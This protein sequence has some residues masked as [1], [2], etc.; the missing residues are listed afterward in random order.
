VST[1][2]VDKAWQSKGLQAYS[3]EAIVG[4]LGH[5]GAPVAE[6]DFRKLA[7]TAWPQDIALQWGKQWKGTGPFKSFPYVA[8]DEL[9]RR[10]VPE[11]L[12][13]RE[14]AEALAELMGALTALLGGRQDAPVGPAFERMKATRQKVPVDDKGQPQLAFV[15]RALGG[16]DEKV[17][18]LFDSM[19][20]ALA[21]A[22]HVGHAEAFA[23]FEE[24]LLPDRRGI[25][26]AVVRA[27]KGERDAAITELENI[28][29]EASRT[30]MAR[31]L[32]VDAMI[33]LAAWP[34]AIARARPMMAQAEKEE[35]IHLALDLC[36]RL[37]HIYK[38][39][40]DRAALQELSRDSAR[41]GELHDR[42]HPGHRHRH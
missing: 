29:A 16:F 33:H 2:R 39:M 42:M 11:K 7:E 40:G 38:A 31:L 13:P 25:A 36:G 12:A 18:E 9:W 34:Q 22:G 23:E 8:A 20:E 15:E 32:A 21:K 3:T 37:Q 17:A 28:S 26:T 27:A 41:L 4:T 24:F 6:A 10:W 30:S 35:D 14:L 5:Y 19:A 1:E